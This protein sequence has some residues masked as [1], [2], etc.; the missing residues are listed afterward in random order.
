MLKNKANSI[1]KNMD[2]DSDQRNFTALLGA[3]NISKMF[4]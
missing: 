3:T 2:L 1:G 4:R